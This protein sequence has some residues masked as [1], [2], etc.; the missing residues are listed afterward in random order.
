M[1]TVILWGILAIST[2]LLA[3]NRVRGHGTV[4]EALTLVA[5][6]CGSVIF[7]D[8]LLTMLSR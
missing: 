1:T 8:K 2:A 7:I 6:G 3:S 4:A 5:L